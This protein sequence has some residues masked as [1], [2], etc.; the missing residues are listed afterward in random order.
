METMVLIALGCNQRHPRYGRPEAVVRV[1]LQAL[2]IRVQAM[3]SL[4]RTAAM[5]PPQPDYVNACV[6]GFTALEPLQL[7]KELKALERAFGRRK[8]RRWGQRVLDLDIL[9]YGQ[10]T[11]D[12]KGLRVPHPGLGSRPFVLWPLRQI[13]SDW[14][15]PRSLAS[16]KQ[17]ADRLGG[18]RRVLRLDKPRLA[19]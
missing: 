16:I 11:I 12:L 18:R 9:A 4:W 8:R 1:A 17:L 15:P 6:I 3:S 2:P 10:K 7:L 19:L 14:R 13:A 5:G